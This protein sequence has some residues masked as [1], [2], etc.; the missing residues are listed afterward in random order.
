MSHQRLRYRGQEIVA[1]ISR[2]GDALAVSRQLEDGVTGDVVRFDARRVGTAEFV[3]TD[4]ADG[5]R[6]HTVFAV[7]ERDQLWVHVDGRTWLLE[8]VRARGGASSSPGVLT[9]PI[10]ATVQEVLVADGDAVEAGQVLAVLSAMKMQLEIKAP[11][12]GTV[13]GLKLKPGDQVAAGVALLQVVE[14]AQP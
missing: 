12:A 8:R 3:V 13:K 7:R 9:A 4:P 1:E 5:G 11:H 6:R 2:D 14:V 10:P